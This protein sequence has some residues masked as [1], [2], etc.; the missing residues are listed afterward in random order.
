VVYA[1]VWRPPDLPDVDR[2]VNLYQVDPRTSPSASGGSL[3]F[4]RPD[5]E[6]LRGTQTVFT[7]VAAFDRLRQV[8]V[9]NGHAEQVFGE[10]VS[11][12]Y[13][14]L[15]GVRPALGR[16]IQPADDV[17]GAVPVAVL[18]Y[19]T[20]QRMF[21]G[22][23]AAIG[24][25]I[26]IKG[27][28]FDVIGVAAP[29][30]H[31]S[32]LASI[33]S[34]AIWVPLSSADAF[35][36]TYLADAPANRTQHS[37][38][39]KG[40]LQPGRTVADA[41]AELAVIGGRLDQAYP[42][43]HDDDPAFGKRRWAVLP[44]SDV[45]VS[46]NMDRLVMPLAVTLMIAVGLVP[47]V[48]CT[49]LANLTLARGAS[50]RQEMAV[51]LALGASRW[52]LARGH[53]IESGMVALAGGAAGLLVARSLM[54]YL[55]SDIPI[56]GIGL[57]THTSPAL[58]LSVFGAAVIATVL[59]LVV[60]GV[61]P[62]LQ[63]ARVDLRGALANDAATAMSPRWRGKR[64]LITGQVT[65]S[66]VLLAL[67]AFCVGQVVGQS[68][69]NTGLDLDHV[70]LLR[71]D[72]DLQK[73]DEP[74]ARP[75][76]AAVL[77]E[78]RR[79]PG[80][81]AVAVSSGPSMGGYSSLAW[82]TTTDR[83]FVDDRYAG[84]RTELFSSTPQIFRTLG[85]RIER[86]RAL[87]DQDT[88]GARGVIVLSRTAATDVFGTTDV[89]GQDVLY[90]PQPLGTEQPLVTALTVV[91][92]AADTDVD[93]RDSRERAAAYVP[94][95]QQYEPR[96]VFSARTS[97]DPRDLVGVLRKAM[98]HVD[99]EVATIEAGTGRAMVGTYNAF[100]GIM[101]GIAGAL[102]VIALVLAL[103]GLFGVLSHV[104]DRRRREI[105][106]RSAL[107]ASADQIIGMVIRDGMRPVVFGL[108]C[109]AVIAAIG[110]MSLRPI[111][112]KLPPADPL[113]LSVVPVLF[114]LAGLVACYLPAR[115]AS[116][117]DPN[118]ALRDL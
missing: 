52:R 1:V 113:V 70:A 58:D 3:S 109:G 50:R 110:R 24:Y 105:G 61:S 83:P 16:L 9:A 90:H 68:S 63:A 75:L 28:S 38:S 104:V 53:L 97:G 33:I 89:V 44:A 114:T 29:S 69:R 95:A 71:V 56:V 48:A 78:V 80:V 43:G 32:S 27:A 20:W 31:G 82:V 57:T 26:K 102:G 15:L 49:N 17:P 13:F 7:R 106:V 112:Q 116:R 4:S 66:V 100:F 23:P 94:F 93:G 86:G 41:A 92:V 8:L 5:Y 67:T 87:A 19:G 25:T 51:R 30:F 40:R 35:G 39:A 103:A 84:T 22:D 108:A 37:L 107:G 12:D 98:A 6:D 55:S 88:A 18:S 96:L 42:I 34:S 62:A 111:F 21:A 11:G 45:H 118:V 60:F 10:L 73:Y 76:V 77:D 72:F 2:I 59:A 91:G 14:D 46:E 85:V 54:V 99:P 117:I 74:R 47:L 79:Q 64:I 101:G 65:V 115:R 81:A 36:M